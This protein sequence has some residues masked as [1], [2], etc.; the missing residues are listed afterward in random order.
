MEKHDD[1]QKPGE[2]NRRNRLQSIVCVI[3]SC[4]CVCV[5]THLRAAGKV[6]QN[7]NRAQG[8]E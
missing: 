3:V 2:W 5:L 4:V 6:T 8:K 7:A 1:E